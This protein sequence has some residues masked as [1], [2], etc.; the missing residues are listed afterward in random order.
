[1]LPRL[2]LL[3]GVLV[4][5]APRTAAAQTRADTFAVWEGLLQR[6]HGR[7]PIILDRRIR[8][9]KDPQ[10]LGTYHDPGWLDSL[11][12]AQLIAGTCDSSCFPGF[13]SDTTY[14]A[15]GVPDFTS[16]PGS[17]LLFRATI[18]VGGRRHCPEYAEEERDEIMV[19]REGHWFRLRSKNVTTG[20]FD[21]HCAPPV[22]YGQ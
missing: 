20:Y 14:Y 22:R 10:Q 11:L 18:L 1:M 15:L 3:A 9:L 19:P 5:S 21:S 8:Q 16:Q 12:A 17:V 2:L 4:G 6:L 7:D 13:Q